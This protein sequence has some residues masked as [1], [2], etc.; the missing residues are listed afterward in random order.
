[1]REL[2]HIAQLPILQNRVYGTMHEARACPRGDVRLV[3]DLKTGLIYNADFCPERM[4]YDGNYQNEQAF[5]IFFQRHLL[6]VAEIV[7]RTIGKRSIIEIGCGKGFFL[8]MLAANGFDI[9]GFD[10]TYEGRNPTIVKAYFDP[11]VGIRAEGIVLRHVLEHIKDPITFLQSLNEANGKRG[12]IYI[13]VP[14][15][16]WII[17]HYAWFDIYYEHVN[18][19]RLIDLHRMFACVYESGKLFG[20]Q[21][22]YIVADLNS[23]KI[24]RYNSNQSVR[25]PPDFTRKIGVDCQN[26]EDITAGAAIWG[27]AS[28]GVIFALLRQREEK[29]VSTV[30]DINPAK[31]GKYLPATGLRVESPHTALS[32]LPRGSVI[33]V[34][35]SNYLDE[36]KQMSGNAYKYI[37]VSHGRIR[38]RSRRTCS[39]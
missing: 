14:C 7:E 21:Y 8:E 18:Y 29:P 17:E 35:N 25:F 37:G 4:Q 23:L 31:Q 11:G 28:K 3:E 22:I 5:S 10:P 9:M 33:F 27:A 20:E 26:K 2:Y 34:M 15:F 1:M 12:K 36:I 39:Y 16:D 13:E 30:I 6:K 38:T 24:P 19:F 32:V